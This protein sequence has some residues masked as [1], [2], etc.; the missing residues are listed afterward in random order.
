ME[1]CC[2]VETLSDLSESADYSDVWNEV[3]SND[4]IQERIL[5]NP[6]TVKN[7]PDETSQIDELCKSF[8]IFL[9][10]EI[11]ND[12]LKSTL[13]QLSEDFFKKLK[14]TPEENR[15]SSYLNFSKQC[16]E[17]ATLNPD[18]LKLSC[19]HKTMI[20]MKTLLVLLLRA[21]LVILTFGVF[22]FHKK[23]QNIFDNFFNT[24]E[25][26]QEISIFN[27]KLEEEISKMKDNS[28]FTNA[29]VQ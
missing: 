6:E 24:S 4:G 29:G 23:W 2:D 21:L 13:V 9:N 15:E 5:P 11:N 25:K 22:L 8:I 20:W 17:Q 26:H 1:I 28:V 12:H 18:N 16:L 10:K 27:N 19:W 14:S 3:G 7:S